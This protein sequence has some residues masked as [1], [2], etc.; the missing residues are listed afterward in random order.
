MK[1]ESLTI[2]SVIAAIAASL[3]CIGPAIAVALGLSAFGLAAA[4]ESVRPYLLALTF[5][6]LAIAFYRAYRRQPDE[7]CATAVCEKPVFRRAQ[8]LFL[9]FGAVVVVVF[10]AFPYY[11]GVLWKTLGP[12]FQ[13]AAASPATAG[14]SRS[15]V[16]TVDDLNCGGCA[17]AIERTLSRLGGVRDLKLNYDDNTAHVT[18]D[19]TRVTAPQIEAK[20]RA[21]GV[22]VVSVRS[23]E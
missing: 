16:I 2:T 23:N 15:A 13:V 4:F 12:P 10:A 22:N 5:G 20:V 6:I 14:E 17:A 18:F 9:W 8:V 1:V 19:R 11:S 21:A 3:C 7:N